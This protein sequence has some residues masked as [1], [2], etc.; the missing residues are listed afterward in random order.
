MYLLPK[1]RK[2]AETDELEVEMEK[3][4]DETDV[5]LFFSIFAEIFKT[6]K[7]DL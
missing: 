7:N 1:I 2:L 4:G 6:I 5:T 3:T